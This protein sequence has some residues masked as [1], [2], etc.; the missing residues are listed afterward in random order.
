MKYQTGKRDLRG[1]QWHPWVTQQIS[2]SGEQKANQ[3]NAK[4]GKYSG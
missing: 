3:G 2:F 1:E 4:S